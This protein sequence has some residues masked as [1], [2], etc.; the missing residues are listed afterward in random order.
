MFWHIVKREIYDNMTSLRFGFTVILLVLL[1]VIN[2]VTFMTKGYKGSIE[3]YRE[4]TAESLGKLSAN[5]SSVYNLVLEG[6]G[7]LYKKPSPLTFCADGEEENIPGTAQGGPGRWGSSWSSNGFEYSARGVWRMRYPSSDRN[8]KN[9]MP[10]YLKTDWA[11]IIGVLVS[12]V[13]ILFT[14]DSISGEKERGTLRLILSNAVPRTSV[15]LGKFAGAFISIMLPLFIAI[16]L[17]LLIINISGVVELDAGHW[18]KIG[19]MVLISTIYTAIF[20]CLGIFVSVRCERSST[21]LLILLLTWV[22]FV[23]LMP[24]ILG[25]I[26]SGL[27]K[28]PSTD[29]ISRRKQTTKEELHKRYVA[30]GLLKVAPSRENPDMKAIQLWADYLNE[31]RRAEEKIMDEHLDAQ[32]AQ[33]QLARQITRISPTAIYRYTLESISNTGFERHRKFIA[34]VRVYRDMFWEYIKSEDQRDPDSLHVYFVREGVSDKPANFNN[35]PRF[36]EYLTLTGALHDA[37]LDIAILALFAVFFFMASHI[38][39]IRADVK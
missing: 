5:C 19:L 21:S 10:R 32:L 2:A 16:L 15:I 26:S 23:V 22:V 25:T 37:L 28:V 33:I 38:S 8:L 13:G 36:T 12:F 39:F 20:I 18:S 17:N 14:F 1:M 31:E 34:N 7:D 3:R 11:F 35:A 30:R 4:G 29:E 6:P 9:I 27:K 24:N